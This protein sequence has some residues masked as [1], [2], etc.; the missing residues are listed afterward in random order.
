MVARS[1]VTVAAAQR[2]VVEGLQKAAS[3]LIKVLTY[4]IPSGLID[5]Y[6]L[7]L[8]SAQGTSPDASNDHS[9]H[10]GAAECPHG[11]AASVG[12]MFIVVRK[13]RQGSRLSIS[14][15]KEGR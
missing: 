14:D 13:E 11:A 2:P 5:P 4:R 15:Q 7:R 9:I 8:Q 10:S 12:V 6:P 3:Q 1:S